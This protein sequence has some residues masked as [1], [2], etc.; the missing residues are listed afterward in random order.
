MENQVYLVKAFTKNKFEW[1]PAGVVL[2]ADNLSDEQMLNIAKELNFSETAFVSK[3]N[4]ADYKIRFFSPTQEVELCAHAMMSAVY[5]IQRLSKNNSEKINYK[6]ETKVWI[7]PVEYAK[8]GLITMTQNT[9]EIIKYNLDKSEIV[10]FLGINKEDFLNYKPQI[11]STWVPKLIVWIKSLEKLFEIKP[12][13]E[14]IK[15]FCKG[16]WARWIYVFTEKIKNT[17]SDFHARQFNPLAWINEDPITW[18]AA[19]ALWAYIKQN[20]ISNKNKF[21]I[22]QGYIMNKPWEIIVEI[23]WDKIEN[24][25]NIDEVKVWWYAVIFGK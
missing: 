25:K 15:N 19:G 11:I 1:N 14:K 16:S 24:I 18:V 8:N 7:I 3:S 21:I 2:N 9:P 12:D 17:Q 22:E 10:D 13:F 6:L 4:K 20:N 5:I 23:L